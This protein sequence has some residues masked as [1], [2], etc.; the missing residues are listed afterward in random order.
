MKWWNWIIFDSRIFSQLFHSLSTSS[1]GS[2][3]PLHFLPLQWYHLHIRSCWYLSSQSWFSLWYIQPSFSHEVHWKDWWWIWNANTLATWCEELTR[4]KRPWC[5]K[6]LKVRRE[7]GDRGWDGWMAS[8][9]QWIWVWVNSRSWWW[10]GRPG[11]LQSIR[12]QRVGLSYWTELC[13]EIKLA[14]LQYSTLT[15]SVPYF[16]PV[17]CSM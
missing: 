9:T 1:R 16:K 10:T 14:E 4:L 6:R 3:I 12:S 8:L 11:V 7:G 15:N 17:S 2:L 5:C 13:I